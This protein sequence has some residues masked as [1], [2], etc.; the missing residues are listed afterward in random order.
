M[1]FYDEPTDAP[2]LPRQPGALLPD[3]AAASPSVSGLNAITRAAQAITLPGWAGLA[4]EA[5]TE[6][7]RKRLQEAAG[8]WGA[9]ARQ[10][11]DVVSAYNFARNRA[12]F[13][14]DPNHNPLDVIGNT[15]YERDH[16]MKFVGSRSEADTRA[17]MSQ[18]DQERAD[19]K[20]LDAAG[21]GGTVAR[22]GAGLLDP[23]LFIPGGAVYRGVRTA[24]T[25]GKT[26]LSVGAAAAL[27]ASVSETTLL[28][29]QQNRTLGQVGANISGAAI[30]G[31]ILGGA[32]GGLAAH[33][34]TAAAKAVDDVRRGI[35]QQINL[36]PSPA[37]MDIETLRSGDVSGVPVG[38]AENGIF[39][40]TNEWQIVPNGAKVAIYGSDGE[41]LNPATILRQ[42]GTIIARTESQPQGVGTGLPQS[43]GAASAGQVLTL[44]SAFGVERATAHL[45]PVTRLQTSTFDSA[46]AV[47]RDMADAGLSYRQNWEG[48][49]T[50]V[51]GTVETRTK[52]WNAPLSDA[53]A[54][55][56]DAYARY[57]FGREEVGAFERRSAA[58]RSGWARVTGDDGKMTLQE[59]REEVGKAMARGDTHPVPQVQ[60]VA[61]AFRSK[62]YDPL[63]KEAQATKL[64]EGEEAGGA[65]YKDKFTADQVETMK[66]RNEHEIQKI[67]LTVNDPVIAQRDPQMVAHL[68]SQGDVLRKEVE[69]QEAFLSG[70]GKAKPLIGAES[71]ITRVYDRPRIIAERDKF[72]NIL[73]QHFIGQRDARANE[74]K[75]AGKEPDSF[76][77][78]DRN[79]VNELVESVT[80]NILGEAASRLAG[81]RMAGKGE[82][83]LKARVL[84]VPDEMLEPYLIRDIEKVSRAYVKSLAGDVELARKFG[85][86]QMT[87][88]LQ[89]LQ[90]EFNAKT[91][92]AESP[93][94]RKRLD[95]EY[96]AAARDIGALRDR[97]RGTYGASSDPDG[98]MARA[99]R[100]AL[101]LNYL[102][103]LGG[104]TLS[105]ITDLARP[106]M[107]YGTGAFRDG[108]VPLVTNL[109]E[110][111]L[112]A[113]EVRL[114]GTALDMVRDQRLTELGDILD[115]FGR[116]SKFERGVQFLTDRFGL[117]TLMSPWNGAVK[118]MAGVITMAEVIRATKAVA[119][120]KPTAR[121]IQRLASDGVDEAMARRIWAEAEKSG[122]DVNGV[123]LPNTES[124]ADPGAVQA[125]R[126]VLNREV[127]TL[128][129]TPGLEK[130]LWMS[131]DL[132]RIIGQFKSFAAA[133]TQRTMLA[134]LQQKD[135]AALSGVMV[136]LALGALTAKI[137]ATARGEDT[138]T[139]T[140][141]RWSAEAL[142]N[143]GLLGIIGEA[144]NIA[145][146]WTGGKVGLARLGGKEVSRY[147]S[148][149]AVGALLG[150]TFDFAGEMAQVTRAAATGEV[151][152]TDVHALRQVLPF[153]NLF[154]VRG[155]F[156]KAEN[157]ISDRLNLPAKRESR[158]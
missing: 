114:A 18:I 91:A 36:Q 109:S 113:R 87:E 16:L 135:A 10:E 66:A 55:L 52:M 130:P 6:G 64:V 58:L 157:A 56:D 15:P 74:L 35:D 26:A 119:T 65:L 54:T 49:P 100:M 67:D 80:N 97:V 32:I 112:A 95:A 133:S 23:T 34:V 137:K 106:I 48:I 9:A 7:G 13:E 37:K 5:V 72:Q 155:L 63:W 62:V 51:G 70:A 78:M 1:P 4:V 69:A 28:A 147:Q 76:A 152:R 108:W 101:Q 3:P 27:Q 8:V 25:V 156:D 53:T 33:E 57:F 125:F 96:K 148:R 11:N 146:K 30:A 12:G 40:P 82:N 68:K 85:D 115:D 103:R 126:A 120:G 45:S 145:D 149:N 77:N 93:T 81:L 44:E 150:P 71:Y 154:Y 50:S 22:V 141:R 104:M 111:K 144:G 17:I 143:S 84:S 158:H 134:G 151:A 153:Q 20:L 14:V 121:Q 41:P 94:E 60:E 43:G 75:L 138:S 98:M 24:E 136:T 139:W 73:R 123:F 86:P 19:D 142:D 127:D 92:A 110:V 90:D 31:G 124:W 140:A 61:Q 116:G 105:S 88:P 21:W 39:V 132:G 79:A 122:N 29:T 2:V 47:V 59:F 102:A 99:G 83:P 131:K 118:S 89:K 117:V 129:V 38:K 42:D 128:I 46:K 107:R